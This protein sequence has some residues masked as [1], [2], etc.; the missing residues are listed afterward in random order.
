MSSQPKL[1]VLEEHQKFIEQQRLKKEIIVGDIQ[2][3]PH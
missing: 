3:D 2:L 1:N